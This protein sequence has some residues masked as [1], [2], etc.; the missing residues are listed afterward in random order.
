MGIRIYEPANRSREFL[1]NKLSPSCISYISNKCILLVFLSWLLTAGPIGAAQIQQFPENNSAS[2]ER[3][4][5]QWISF[6][7][8]DTLIET[9][10]KRES[11]TSM[12][13]V[14]SSSAQNL[15]LAVSLPGMGI[16]YTLMEDSLPYYPLIVPG[17]GE[18]EIGR[19]DIPIFGEWIVIPNGT[20]LSILVDPGEPLVFYNIDIP[21][22]QPPK[23]DSPGADRPEFTKDV[24]TYST[25]ADYPGV[26]VEA[27]PIKNIRG[28]DCTVVWLYPYQYNPITR[29]LSVYKDLLV[30]LQFDGDIQPIP[31]RL[32]SREFETIL[33]RLA[34]NA[35]AVLPAQQQIDEQP[36]TTER[37]Y[38]V[39]TE[40]EPH[41]V[42]N[43]EIGGCDY[44]IICDPAFQIAAD[45]LA[46]WKRLSGFRTKVVTTNDTGTTAAD[47][48]SYID[49]SQQDWLPAPLY[50]L[51][52]G[53]AEYIPCFYKLPHASDYNRKDGLMQGKVAS[54]R[55]YGDTNDDGVA[56]LFV[57]RLPVDTPTEAQIAVDRII[58][59]ERTPPDPV[60][61]K[62]FY[63]NFATVAYFDDDHPRDGY[64][65]TRFVNTSEDICQYLQDANYSGQRIYYHD[66]DVNPTHWSTDFV[67]ENDEGGGQPLPDYLLSP[68]FQ[69]DGSTTD[70]SNAI[71]N[72]VFLVT[73]RGHGSRFMRSIPRGWSYLGGWIQPEFQEDD[74][75]ALT[76]GSLVPVVF[77]P[78]CMTGWFD[79]ET[80]E[81]YEV[82]SGGSV[83]RIY[84]SEFD[85]ECLCEHF[86]L[87]ANGGAVGTIGATRVSYSGRND[88][89]TWGWMDAIWPDFIEY[90]NGT[91]GDS[92]SIY[93]M[94]PVFEYGKNYML[95]KYSYNWDYTKTTIDEFIW[96]GDPT[97]EIRTGIPEPL[98]AFDV[99]H[100]SSINVGLPTDVTITIQKNHT[101]LANAR[102][103]ISRASA[104]NDYWTDL[105]N[106][107]GNVTFVELT[108]S[109]QGNYNIVVTAHNCLPYEGIIDSESISL[110]AIT[111]ERQVSTCQDDWYASNKT[112]QTLDTDYLIIGSS[113]YDP[114]PYYI[115]GMVFRNVNV[116]LGANIISAYLRIRSY[117]R[118][119]TELV[120]GRIEAEAIDDTADFGDSR[121]I[122]SLS[123]TS[124]SVD[125]DLYEPWSEDTWYTSPDIADVIQ[126]VVGREGWSANN[127]LAIFYSTRQPEGGYRC[128]SSYDRDDPNA[129]KLEITYAVDGTWIV[130]GRVTFKG[131]GLASVQ[132]NGF[133]GNAVTDVNGYYSAEVDF[134]WSG[135]VAPS[136][137]GYVFTP[138]HKEYSSITF[139]QTHN[140][141][142]T[143]QTYTVSGYVRTTGGSGIPG[144]TVSANNGGG[145]GTTD[146][147]GYYS[148]TVPHSWSGRIT[149]SKV[150]YDVSPTYRDYLSV[151]YNWT[152]QNYTVSAHT[153]SGYVRTS[154][155]SGISGVT[156]SVSDDVRSG[157]TDSTGYY[158]LFVPHGWSGQ[159]TPSKTGYI[160]S[161]TYRDHTNITNDRTNQDY[162]G[163]VQTYT[164]SGYVYTSDG[165]GISGVTVLANNGGSSSTTSS[166]GYYSLNV[167]HGWSGI[168]TPLKAGYFFS[169]AYREYTNIT[170]NRDDRNYVKK[171]T[172]TI[173]G[174]VRTSSG[175]G[176][177]GVIV[178]A[179]NGGGSD[180][181]NAAGYY[182]VTVPHGW[183]GRVIPSKLGYIFSPSYREYTSVNYN[184][185]NR[186]YTA[187]NS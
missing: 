54:D 62:D 156:V 45:T 94:G 122:G 90:H 105:T 159:I 140:Y 131:S 116:P 28:Q 15:S 87:N 52:L 2:I 3:T 59:Y 149:T 9:L 21:P 47:I 111:V 155:G 69:W 132:M 31:K 57:G 44:L 26:F 163:T 141:T 58:N 164:I 24:I 118:Y 6:G 124:A 185:T 110:G 12:F 167:P 109:Q 115:S 77:G 148:L 10:S 23:P 169:P 53:D 42:G 187:E 150:A 68:Y 16:S 112:S 98:T 184:R 104:P 1:N 138:S 173:S 73:Y 126:E 63:T 84:E 97:M 102:V 166:K 41:N 160:F 67:F 177:S 46:N 130:S 172:N 96:F 32:K 165:S 106:A 17:S 162:K 95:T 33:K 19:P 170:Y 81:E 114:P 137:A 20:C 152:S 181:T 153:I 143:L 117:D 154:G 79:N 139:N 40:T 125:W 75:A 14:V 61:N 113:E 135:R 4:S 55:Y 88:R 128:F 146:S 119:L 136:K 186:N 107:S 168:V 103:T 25:N 183:S 5:P 38:A 18:F 161:P 13:K 76:N 142:A 48:E 11:N 175:L 134:G 51:L 34:V 151:T 147:T 158:I 37:L 91:Y 8:E 7:R 85:N 145:S 101:A 144:M 35:D 49:K 74:V 108:T 83:V 50:V 71:N 100:P 178:S 29:R 127:S 56:D 120:Y 70:I 129:P 179:N 182:S 30:E 99:T 171:Q 39:E 133:P 43:G 123:K 60:T 86:I 121:L 36:D 72:G 93:Q 180:T 176:I 22:V 65:D 92:N 174:Y 66:A 157:T 78:T 89:L 82:Y 80:D 64:A 27:E